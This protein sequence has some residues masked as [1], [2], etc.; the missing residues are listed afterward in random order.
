M[1]LSDYSSDDS[2]ELEE[3]QIPQKALQ[4]L[5]KAKMSKRG[6]KAIDAGPSTVSPAPLCNFRPVS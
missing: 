6:S 2:L 5:Q 1:S 4:G 3:S